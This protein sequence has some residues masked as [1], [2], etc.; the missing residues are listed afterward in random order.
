[1]RR[2]V[3]LWLVFPVPV[4]VRDMSANRDHPAAVFACRKFARPARR[5]LAKVNPDIYLPEVAST[6][7]NLAIFDA[8]ENRMEVARKEFQEALGIYEQ[9][10]AQNP[11]G[12]SLTLPTF[13]VCSRN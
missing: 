8:A 3:Q 5:E 4:D 9:L 13:K 6:L 10:A 1:M 7:Y 2:A 11:I 12:F